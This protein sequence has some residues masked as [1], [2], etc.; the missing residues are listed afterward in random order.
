MGA[1]QHSCIGLRA[2]HIT[3]SGPVK[4]C[5]G[6]EQPRCGDYIVTRYYDSGIIQILMSHKEFIRILRELSDADSHPGL[7]SNDFVVERW[8]ELHPEVEKKV[9]PRDEAYDGD[10]NPLT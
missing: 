6:E 9:Q 3:G 7:S 5:R 1:E 10:G 2:V 8:F 4:T